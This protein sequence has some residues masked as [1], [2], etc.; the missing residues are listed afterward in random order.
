MRET[1]HSNGN[2]LARLFLLAAGVLALAGCATG[3]SLMQPD[4]SGAGGYY[5]GEG[6]Y[7]APGYY[8]EGDAGA[9]DP[10]DAAFG[11]GSLYGPTF[12]FGLGWGFGFGS[13]CGWNCLGYYGGWPWYYGGGTQG[14]RRHRGRHHHGDPIVSGPSPRPWLNPDHP[15]V[16]SANGTRA[17]IPPIAVPMEGI[18]DRRPLQSTSFAP[19]R[20]N[21]T[22]LPTTLPDHP[23]YLTPQLPALGERRMPMQSSARHDFARP[24]APAFAPMRAMPPPA[25]GGHG[26]SVRIPQ[27]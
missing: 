6:L 7:S 25:H 16:P 21:R 26:A 5:T 9:F 20:I 12:T 23:A 13:A 22:S 15:R 1:S 14:W 27:T 11:Y 10:Y 17:A 24:A 18:A 2:T 4:A 8:Y 3:Y 19:H